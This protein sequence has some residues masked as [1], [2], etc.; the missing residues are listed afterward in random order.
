MAGNQTPTEAQRAE[1]NRLKDEGNKFFVAGDFPA[2]VKSF[3]AAIDLDGTNHVLFSNRSGAYLSLKDSA[4]ALAD[5][6]ACVRINAGWSKGYSRLGAALYALGRYPEAVA[7]Y[8]RGVGLDPTNSATMQSLLS[9]QQAA[10]KAANPAGAGGDGDVDGVADGVRRVDLSGP[11]P[12]PPT[13]PTPGSSSSTGAGSGGGAP[14]SEYSNAVIG[15]DLGTTY[16][17]V[18]LWENDHVEILTNSEGSRT[19]ASVVSFCGDERLIGGPAQAQA[20]GNAANTI[21]DAKRLIG[22]SIKEH[23]VQDD[24]KRIPYKVVAGTDGESPLIEVEYKG[25]VKRFAPEEI[26]AM[27]LTKMKETAE[28]Y[29][30]KKVKN[31]V[32]TVPAYFS[33][34]QRKAT[35]NAGAIAGLEVKRIVNE[36]TAAALA[37]GLDRKAAEA[38]AAASGGAEGDDGS[39]AGSDDDVGGP[40]GAGAGGK[41]GFRGKKKAGKKGGKKESSGAGA[42]GSGYVLIFDLG[43]GTFDV[44]LLTIE[45]GIFEVKATG[46]DTH[47]GGEDFDSAIMDWAIAE[48]TRKHKPALTA[49]AATGEMHSE[50]KP[51]GNPGNDKRSM[52]RLRTAC[53]RAKRMLSASTQ[54]QLE[55]D[56]FYE[57]LDLN[58]TLTRAKFE[59]LNDV[60]FKKCIDKVKAVLKD[61]K[62]NPSE[63]GDVVL[64]GGSTRIPKIQT[65][66]SEHFG[67]KELCKSI[68]PDEAVA[69]G[70]A[71]QGAILSGARSAA[72]QALVLVDV[73]P[74]SLGIETEGKVMS[75]VIKRNTPI[76]VRKTKQF[77]TTE[78][79]QE[80]VDVDV[81]EGERA[82]TEGNNHLGDFVISGIERAKRGVPKI[83]VTFDIDANGILTVSAFDVVTRARGNVTI[84]NSVGHL[85]SD[86]I[87]RMV[88]EAER[89][90]A[91]DAARLQRIEARNEL[92]TLIYYAKEVAEA[93]DSTRLRRTVE[94]IQAW[95]DAAD[96]ATTPASQYRSKGTEVETEMSRAQAADEGA[97]GTGGGRRGGKKN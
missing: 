58:L 30:G 69:Y 83:D 47:L 12:S 59:D 35:K 78:D 44:S 76:P 95:L 19:T 65:M 91:D 5:A 14:V 23:V 96:P 57:G 60:L 27:V 45:D 38:S 31:A 9:A 33:D 63:V 17:C 80:A 51:K 15:I 82:V 74:L 48:F 6:E 87:D 77:S 55:V 16:S 70:A 29:L 86:E 66:L 39:D 25:A 68:N 32:I 43:G 56:A 79:W 46:G 85:S 94:E 72:T 49:M 81:Y 50:G 97:T 24:L 20:A 88:A 52:R 13:T 10:A 75:V 92:E 89:L 93:R 54:T 4:A 40:S 71:V 36:P 11:A 90:K 18:G 67:G 41:K 34:A 1:A 37:Y 62:A 22:R 7:A 42:P 64:V 53:E 73:T 28:A 26:S 21:F 2:A 61:A 8:A 84:T 3:T